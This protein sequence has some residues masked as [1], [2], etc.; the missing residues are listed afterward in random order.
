M[1]KIL[2]LIFD[3]LSDL[4]IFKSLFNKYSKKTRFNFFNETDFI[5]SKNQMFFDNLVKIFIKKY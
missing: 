2:L 1:Y 3:C 4:N 5:L